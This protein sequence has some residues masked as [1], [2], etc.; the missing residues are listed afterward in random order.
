MFPPFSCNSIFWCFLRVQNMFS[1]SGSAALLHLFAHP[2]LAQSQPTSWHCLT[3]AQTWRNELYLLSLGRNIG[4]RATWTATSTFT[5][6]L[7]RAERV[8]FSA[9]CTWQ[10]AWNPGNTLFWLEQFVS[11]A[12]NAYNATA[13]HNQLSD[14]Q[15]KRIDSVHNFAHCH[16]SHWSFHFAVEVLTIDWDQPPCLVSCRRGAFPHRLSQP[17]RLDR[18]RPQVQDSLPKFPMPS[19]N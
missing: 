3:W 1:S 9:S 15:P 18:W 5:S 13:P 4:Q 8:M 19:N 16:R 2:I 7:R 12:C 17:F 10:W 6:H 11:R 14:N